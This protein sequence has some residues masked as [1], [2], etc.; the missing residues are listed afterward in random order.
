MQIETKTKRLRRDETK[1]Q[2]EKMCLEGSIQ[3]FTLTSWEMFCEN[4]LV[5]SFARTEL[6]ETW[7]KIEKR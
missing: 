1:Q 2:C 5:E 7:V 4:S 6:G 3:A